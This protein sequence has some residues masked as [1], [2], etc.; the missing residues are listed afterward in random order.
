MALLLKTYHCIENRRQGAGLRLVEELGTACVVVSFPVRTM[1]GRTA[2]FVPGHLQ[3][4][5]ELAGRRG[6]EQ[7]RGGLPGEELVVLVKE[8]RRGQCG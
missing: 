5:T 7:R 2:S 4:L 1:S 6:W 8:D 3:R